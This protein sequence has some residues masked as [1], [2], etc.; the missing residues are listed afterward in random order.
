MS[1]TGSRFY[2][3]SVQLPRVI[4]RLGPLR[5][6]VGSVGNFVMDKSKAPLPILVL[7]DV[8]RGFVGPHTSEVPGNIERFLR[9]HSDRF[10]SVVAT[11]FY[12]P[13]GSNY[14]RLIGWTRLQNEHETELVPEIT[15]W[16]SE[17]ID[18]PTYAAVDEISAVADKHSTREIVFCGI[19]TDVCVLQNAAGV[20]DAGYTPSVIYD[21]C[22]TGG[23]PEAHAAA[24]PLLARTIGRSQVIESGDY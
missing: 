1:E 15:R 6:C 10:S 24:Y 21:L 17:V 3:N 11:R 9:E 5:I 14:E 7:I 18:K 2:S 20:F 23:G 4:K 8:Q 22:A 12:N 19:D 16:V 13:K